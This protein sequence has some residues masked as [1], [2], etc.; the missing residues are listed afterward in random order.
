MSTQLLLDK[1]R[2]FFKLIYDKS[3]TR[4]S[5]HHVISLKNGSAVSTSVLQG[6]IDRITVHL[7]R[8]IIPEDVKDGKLSSCVMEVAKKG[9]KRI[10]SFSLSFD[11]TRALRDVLDKAIKTSEK[12]RIAQTIQSGIVV[13]LQNMQE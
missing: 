6:D 1:L 9:G 13:G 12:N 7:Q 5:M 4:Q 8:K 2:T 3:V 11:A 10:T